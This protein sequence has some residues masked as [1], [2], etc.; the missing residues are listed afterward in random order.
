MIYEATATGWHLHVVAT[1]HIQQRRRRRRH[2]RRRRQEEEM[3]PPPSLRT[4]MVRQSLGRSRVSG[5]PAAPATHAFL[6]SFSAAHL[7]V[8]CETAETER[9]LDL[10]V[11]G[12]QPSGSS[13]GSSATRR[14]Q[15]APP[16]NGQP[17]GSA[18]LSR[19]RIHSRRRAVIHVEVSQ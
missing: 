2:R 17:P 6:V 16:P 7:S 5:S 3:S 4:P 8:L 18:A 12:R 13:M 11:G 14:Q 9:Q 1:T 10:L 19:C 15:L